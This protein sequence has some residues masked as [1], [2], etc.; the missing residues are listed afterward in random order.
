MKTIQL[1]LP[2]PSEYKDRQQFVC[3]SCDYFCFSKMGLDLHIANKHSKNPVQKRPSKLRFTPV[4]CPMCDKQLSSEQR[5]KQH[6]ANI[7]ETNKAFS[8][9]Q[10]ITAYNFSVKKMDSNH[11]FP[12]L[13]KLALQKLC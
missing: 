2:Y 6:I 3:Q 10:I 1:N 4:N 13:K 7:H 11:F 5:L 8:V 9:S 12:F